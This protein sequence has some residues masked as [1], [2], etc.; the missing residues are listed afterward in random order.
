MAPQSS[1]Y[2][3][4]QV[5]IFL[6]KPPNQLPLTSLPVPPAYVRLMLARNALSVLILI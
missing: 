4:E 3:T 1:A 2:K 6:P 5:L